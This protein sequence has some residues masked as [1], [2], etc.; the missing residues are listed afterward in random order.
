MLSRESGA[1]KAE[2]AWSAQHPEA[3]GQCHAGELRDTDEQ[4]I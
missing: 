4:K 2:T 1:N 3:G